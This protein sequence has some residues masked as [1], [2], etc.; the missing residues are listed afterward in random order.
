MCLFNIRKNHA[1]QKKVRASPPR[2]C[3]HFFLM[4]VIFPNVTQ[5]QS[6]HFNSVY[7]TLGKIMRIL[8]SYLRS[9]CIAL[10]VVYLLC[11]LITLNWHLGHSTLV[12][13]GPVVDFNMID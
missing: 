8:P 10:K 4:R 9:A 3:T 1:R 5:S 6:Y 7:L 13:D 2:F 12:L 11:T